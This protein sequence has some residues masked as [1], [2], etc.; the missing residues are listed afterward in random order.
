MHRGP[1]LV[2]FAHFLVYL[3]QEIEI[4]L[5]G[6]G[7]AFEPLEEEA[8][9]N[10]L[11]GNHHWYFDVMARHRYVLVQLR[12]H[13]QCC[14]A[15]SWTPGRSG[16]WLSWL[17]VLRPVVR[18][19]EEA[20]FIEFLEYVSKRSNVAILVRQVTEELAEVLVE[21]G[22]RRYY[23]NEGWNAVHPLDEQ[24]FPE[25]IL[26][27]SSL[28][29]DDCPLLLNGLSKQ[30]KRV[31]NVYHLREITADVK[32]NANFGA[33]ID[34]FLA[35]RKEFAQRFPS[36][37]DYGFVGWN[38]EAIERVLIECQQRVFFVSDSRN[39]E[40]TAFF[41]LTC[42]GVNT[43]DMALS[44]CKRRENDLHR[45]LYRKMCVVL[46]KEGVDFVN[47]GGSEEESLYRAKRR[48][49]PG[50]ENFATHLVFAR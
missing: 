32:L 33:M 45:L 19:G 50:P 4:V 3:P 44:F 31:F 18:R 42:T 5:P 23:S 38:V 17:T 26:N 25:V 28:R 8:H 14:I 37:V 15:P 7:I 47:M 36:I 46:A 10:R 41:H 9:G 21:M 29:K 22:C 24:A 48:I 13:F 2:R 34:V 43:L 35:W 40:V 20:N 16:T 6:Y 27:L 39:D 12:E 30:A 49:W 1:K 11:F